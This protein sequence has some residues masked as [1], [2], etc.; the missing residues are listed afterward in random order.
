MSETEAK[1]SEVLIRNE[2]GNLCLSIDDFLV[3]LSQMF[4]ENRHVLDIKKNKI[5]CLR[6]KCEILEDPKDENFIYL[7]QTDLA[8][9]SNTLEKRIS[10]DL[11]ITL[12]KNAR[13]DGVSLSNEPELYD[14]FGEMT[15]QLHEKYYKGKTIPFKKMLKNSN[16]IL[17]KN[18]IPILCVRD[19]SA[20]DLDFYNISGCW[21]GSNIENMTYNPIFY[22]NFNV[23]FEANVY[24]S[25]Y[26]EPNKILLNYDNQSG[27]DSENKTNENVYTIIFFSKL[28]DS[29]VKINYKCHDIYFTIS[30][31]T[32]L[33]D[34][35]NMRD[36]VMDNYNEVA[37]IFDMFVEKN[38]D[39]Q[40]KNVF[41]LID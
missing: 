39:N 29:V 30:D 11:L 31:I 35:N 4:E 6:V 28:Y 40:R 14:V 3:E 22:I 24:Y 5:D 13:L 26:Q 37:K 25:L 1:E 12:F 34:Y 15:Y 41:D 21:G 23:P 8:N 27:K 17:L 19:T 9:T 7:K 2:E 20:E 33:D 16:S 32:F 18:D 38:K 10:V 36:F